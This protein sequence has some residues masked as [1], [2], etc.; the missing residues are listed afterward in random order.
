MAAENT[1]S[2]VVIEMYEPLVL[3]ISTSSEF[4]ADMVDSLESGLLGVDHI[5]KVTRFMIFIH[6]VSLERNRCLFV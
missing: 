2:S 4:V 3:F 6:L 1:R 5:D